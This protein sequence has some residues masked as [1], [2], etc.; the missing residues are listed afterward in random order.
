MHKR[1]GFTLIELLVVIA[2][3]ALLM[4]ILTPVLNKVKEAAKETVCKSNLRSV[5][6]GITLYLQDSDYKMANSR[7]TNEFQW[8][9]AS[10]SLRNT[11]DRDAYWGVAYI[12]YIRETKVFGCP[13]FRKVAEL[14]YPEDPEL[15]QEAAFG[16]NSYISG[17]KTTDLSNHAQIIVAHDHA[18][19]KMEQGSVDMFFNDG[20]GTENLTQYRQGGTRAKFYRGIFRHNIRRNADFETGGRANILWLD[21]HVSSLDETTGDNVPEKW[22]TAGIEQNQNWGWGN[23]NI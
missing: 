12:D 13:S 2:I 14:I 17:A 19:P 6:M 7:M 18:E 21:G 5:G 10:G 3:I 11:N 9:D 1:K 16:L 20:P 23:K 22:Y 4:A 15:I 8:Y